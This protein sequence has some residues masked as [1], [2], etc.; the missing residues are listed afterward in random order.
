MTRATTS[1]GTTTGTADGSLSNN[2]TSARRARGIALVVGALVIVALVE[3]KTIKFYWFPTLTGLTYLA[4]AAA[5]RSRGTLWGPGFVITSVGLAAALWLRDGRMPDSFQFLALAVMALG[6]GGV[7]AG[8]LAQAR[9]FSISAMSVSLSV[10][11][12]GVFALLE[13]QA[14]K[15]FA[16]QTWAYA[17]LLALWGAYELRPARRR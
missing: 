5:G 17:V 14:V 12:F 10:L 3:T 7:L 11:L 9:G 16:G 15:P 13:Q 1:T 8:L 4:A 6:L 2:D